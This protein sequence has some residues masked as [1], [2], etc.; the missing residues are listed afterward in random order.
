V[1][2]G[3]FWAAKKRE[4]A[5]RK[6]SSGQVQGPWFAHKLSQTIGT[7]ATVICDTT[8]EDSRTVRCNR[9]GEHTSG[10]K[11]WQKIA[12]IVTQV[13]RSLADLAAERSTP[14]A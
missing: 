4:W 13:T 5:E 1:G 2:E 6:R 3:I 8:T 9:R 10:K 12:L 14:A 11:K 7:T